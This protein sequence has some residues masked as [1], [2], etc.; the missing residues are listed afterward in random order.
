ME[1]LH[2]RDTW[3]DALACL[4]SLAHDDLP[5]LHDDV[6]GGDVA[7]S[8]MPQGAPV[9]LDGP[10]GAAEDA[11]LSH[12]EASLAAFA[13]ARGLVEEGDAA[14]ASLS[15]WHDESHASVTSLHSSLGAART[16]A[17]DLVAD[18]ERH[19]SELHAHHGTTRATLEGISHDVQGRHTHD[20]HAAFRALVDALDVHGRGAIDDAFRHVDDAITHA[21][22]QAGHEA[23]SH[24][25]AFESFAERLLLESAERISRDA[26]E[27]LRQAFQQLLQHGVEVMVEEVSA[28]VLTM[29]AGS[30]VS[31]ALAPILPEL[32]AA[33]M[34]LH[35]IN[36]VEGLL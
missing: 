15:A 8:T 33:R 11:L 3:D 10:L 35:A 7:A 28:Q 29:T 24:A 34:A 13:A 4:A 31:A 6:D 14:H 1:E 9:D 12:L 25:H 22:D 27:Q 36:F 20:G 5:G 17:H 23:Q 18:V 21:F 16:T 19:R 30:S 26:A 32:V 2:Q